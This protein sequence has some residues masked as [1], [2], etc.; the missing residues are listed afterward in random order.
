MGKRIVLIL[1]TQ[2]VLKCH[3]MDNKATH[4]F[5]KLVRNS[6]SQEI[7]LIL[8][9]NITSGKSGIIH[10]YLHMHESY[11]YFEPVPSFKFADED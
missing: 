8:N 7:N 5:L 2:L 9:Y 6:V 11:L 3:N 10:F 1:F 4:S